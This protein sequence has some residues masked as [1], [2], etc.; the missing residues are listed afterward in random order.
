M[1]FTF[2]VVS[3]KSRYHAL[4][5]E[6]HFLK[7]SPPKVDCLLNSVFYIL[8]HCCPIK[9]QNLK[10][11][12]LLYVDQSNFVRIRKEAPNGY[13]KLT[14]IKIISLRDAVVTNRRTLCVHSQDSTRLPLLIKHDGTQSIPAYITPRRDVTRD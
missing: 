2:K 11:T 1:G 5:G 6:H 4:I 14:G 7:W 9:F 10:K 13:F 12:G 8:Y 3:I